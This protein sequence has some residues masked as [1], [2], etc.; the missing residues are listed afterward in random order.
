MTRF[1]PHFNQGLAWALQKRTL[2]GLL[3]LGLPTL[4]SPSGLLRLANLRLLNW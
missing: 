4:T 2:S 3:N 1:D